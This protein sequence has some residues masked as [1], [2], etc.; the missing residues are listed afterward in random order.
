MT[1]CGIIAWTRVRRRLNLYLRD[2]GYHRD[3]RTRFVAF[4]QRRLILAKAWYEHLRHHPLEFLIPHA[5][6]VAELEDVA[7]LL[8]A[9]VDVSVTRE[10]LDGYVAQISNS[11]FRWRNEKIQRLSTSVRGEI[12]TIPL[13]YDHGARLKL[14]V[15]V[16]ECI[17]PSSI[18]C[19]PAGQLMWHP[20][21]Y[22][23]YCNHRNRCA[24]RP[25]LTDGGLGVGDYCTDEWSLF[26]IPY[27]DTWGMEFIAFHGAA[28]FAAQRV[29]AMCGIDHRSAS[30]ADVDGA[31]PRLMCVTCSSLSSSSTVYIFPWRRAVG[32]SLDFC[33]IFLPSK[34]LQ[35]AHAITRHAGNDDVQW[36][37]VNVDSEA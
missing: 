31:D 29:L 19:Q 8:H 7:S 2:V 36:S 28:S 35:V 33:R 32:L 27:K 21:F 5:A 1:D 37:R 34:S 9:P 30:V 20:E 15:C 24:P 18:A 14:A 23:H 17:S 11:V 22:N 26:K 6:D 3:V 25:I 4:H 12:P 13:E 16:F 10:M